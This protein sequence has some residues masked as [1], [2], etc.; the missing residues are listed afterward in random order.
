MEIPNNSV[1]KA[2]VNELAR[3]LQIFVNSGGTETEVLYSFSILPTLLLQKPKYKCTYKEASQ[4]LRRRLELWDEKNLDLLMEEGQCIQQQF[5][6]KVRGGQLLGE[7]DLARRFGS[8]MSMGRVHEALRM[9]TEDRPESVSGVLQVDDVVNLKNGSSASVKDLL[10]EKHPRGQPASTSALMSGECPVVNEIQFEALTPA[11]VQ[12]VAKQ[13]QGSA[14]PS[15]LD[16]DAW[17]RLVTSFK[18]ASSTLCQAL[19]DLTRLIAMRSLKA[20]ALTPFLACRLIALNKN[21]GVRPIGVCEVV[22]RIAAKAILRVIGDDIEEACG[23]LQKCSG[24]PAGLEAAVHAMQ[25]MYEEESTEGILLVDAKNAFNSLNREAAL[26]NVKYLCPSL[27]TVLKNCYQAPSR[28]FV[29][30]GGE[31]ASEEG[32][33]QGDPLSMPFYAL[34]TIPLIKHLQLHHPAVRQVWLADDSAGAGRLR[35]LR[36]W[37]DTIV[38]T[39]KRYGYNTNSDKTCLLVHPNLLV[40]AQELFSGT[41]V[42]IV[43]EGTRYLG[44]AIGERSFINSFMVQKVEEWQKELEALTRFAR[45]EPHAA[46]CALTQGLRSRYTYI[47]RTVPTA[48][49]V[50]SA[51]DAHLEEKFLPTI[52]GHHRFTA[53][54]LSLLRLPAR[55]GGIGLPSLSATAD[56]DLAAASSM[57]SAQVK[58]ILLQNVPHE[59]PTFAEVHIAAIKAKNFSA[60]QRRRTEVDTIN[61]L[62]DDSSLDKRQLSLLSSKGV[63]AW[64]TVLPLQQHGFWLSKREFRDAL[65]LRYDWSLD[66]VPVK[67]VCG[68]PFC[69]NHAMVCPFGGYPTIRHNELRD[70]FGN[71]LS[72][73]CHDVVTEPQLSPLSGEVFEHRS[74]N[75]SQEARLDVKARGFWSRQEDTFFDV[76]VFHPNASSYL[77]TSPDE[78]FRRHERQKQLEYEERIVNVEHGSF[79]PLVF[80]TN[81]AV[82]PLC[83]R[84]LQRLSALLSDKEHAEYSTTMAWI[85][86]RVSFALLRNAVMCIRGSRSTCGKPCRNTDRE[87][88]I[89]ESGISA[90][91]Q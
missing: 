61:K 31:L 35:A 40:E 62:M 90:A 47:C 21:P 44:S 67:C 60:K 79:C 85:R 66:A 69:P 56:A 25:Q 78:L 14:G 29:S 65:A 12:K 28:L 84:F 70:F 33:T 22:R 11:L 43:M 32:T 8:R 34:A 24:C 45:T 37:W 16:S 39:G 26:H 59:T 74:T 54:E 87:V 42:Q 38:E 10:E 71:L 49:K 64:L 48:T 20:E 5:R 18:G 63:S 57:T 50:V 82:G 36:Q 89:A 75:T 76:R 9:L 91:S 27:S 72:E 83:N 80:T 68:E 6:T 7:E 15:G 2:F 46:F 55:L 58:E 23:F 41:G 4:H 86:C 17:R 19:A 88:C 77:D 30:G 3:L 73:V 52:T 13:C 1:G 51:L 53:D 81:G